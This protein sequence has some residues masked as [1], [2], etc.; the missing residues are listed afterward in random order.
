MRPVSP[1]PSSLRFSLSRSRCPISVV[2][3][4]VSLSLGRCRR[5]SFPPSFLPR[6]HTL[7]PCV[8]AYPMCMYAQEGESE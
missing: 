8:R 2:D 6:I 1:F 3:A 5:V 7:S 4:V